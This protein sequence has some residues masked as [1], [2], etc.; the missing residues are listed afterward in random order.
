MLTMQG[1]RNLIHAINGMEH[2][3]MRADLLTGM[4]NSALSSFLCTNI[5][6]DFMLSRFMSKIRPAGAVQ[7]AKPTYPLN[8]E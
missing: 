4:P 3:S 1:K 7:Y 8:S 6:A 5:L 2:T